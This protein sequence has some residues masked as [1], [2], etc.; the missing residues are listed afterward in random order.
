MFIFKRSR[1]DVSMKNII[2]QSKDYN[3][4][5]C[6]YPMTESECDICDKWFSQTHKE[7]DVQIEKG[8]IICDECKSKKK[9]RFKI[10]K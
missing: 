4:M 10:I 6:L 9:E 8:E 2:A 3:K 5:K 7:L 1:E